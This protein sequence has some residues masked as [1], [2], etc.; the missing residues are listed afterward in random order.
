MSEVAGS[1]VPVLAQGIRWGRTP[2]FGE[3][4]FA[5]KQRKGSAMPF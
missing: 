1:L 3:R 4:Q 2:A 5:N